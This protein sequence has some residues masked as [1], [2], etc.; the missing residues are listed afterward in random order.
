MLT[1]LSPF[2]SLAPS[3]TEAGGSS[4]LPEAAGPD[5]TRDS[6]CSEALPAG[7]ES[8]PAVAKSRAR[9]RRR[10]G[11]SKTFD[12][13]QFRPIAQA[14]A[15]QRAE[16][17][18]GLRADLDHLERSVRREDRWRRRESVS[19]SSSE[20][21]S[22]HQGGRKDCEGGD[23]AQQSASPVGGKQRVEEEIEQHWQQLEKTPIREERRVPLPAALQSRDTAELQQLLENHKQGVRSRQ[24]P[25]CSE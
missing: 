23:A 4:G 22:A 24:P 7:R 18:G 13:A 8:T 6:I 19:G 12:W 3:S 16:E 25:L 2:L 1:T 21:T 10:E 11:R 5:V 9:E 14:L 15:Q 20:Q 17:A